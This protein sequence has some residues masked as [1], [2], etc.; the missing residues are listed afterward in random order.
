VFAAPPMM[1]S[2]SVIAVTMAA[3]RTRATQL[4]M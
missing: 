2:I 4:A 1:V 3:I